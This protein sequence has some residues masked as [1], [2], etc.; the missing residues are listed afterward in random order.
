MQVTKTFWVH[1]FMAGDI[2][3]A[4]QICRRFCFANGLCVT[5]SPTDYIYTGGQQAGFVVGLIN[6]PRFPSSPEELFSTAARLAKDLMFDLCEES[7]SIETPES[8][9]WFSRR[10]A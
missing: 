9:H 10:A 4:K 8:T 3:V 2:A 1:I 6:Y 5:V 7:F